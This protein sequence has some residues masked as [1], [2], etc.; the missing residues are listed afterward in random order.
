MITSL[1]YNIFAH[2]TDGG[3]ILNHSL[4]FL[5]IDA[6]SWAIFFRRKNK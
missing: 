2:Y 4:L 3:W 5:G 1:L 6:I